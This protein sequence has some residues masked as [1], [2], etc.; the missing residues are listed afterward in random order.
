MHLDALLE[1]LIVCAERKG[2]IAC[3][4]HKQTLHCTQGSRIT[5][6]KETDRTRHEVHAPGR[7][8][9]EHLDQ[10]VAPRGVDAWQAVEH[11]GCGDIALHSMGYSMPTSGP[12]SLPRR[13]S[14][15][16]AK[17]RH[18]T[19]AHCHTTC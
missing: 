13:S 3:C 19:A 15:L 9:V 8:D 4:A 14:S 5:C 6:G 2:R 10:A 12:S 18:S 17:V 7:V 11:L 16:G 1:C